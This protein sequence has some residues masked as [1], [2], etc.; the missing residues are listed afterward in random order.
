M[1]FG[2]V[3]SSGKTGS[4][5]YTVRRP[6]LS[7]GRS[8]PRP[9]AGAIPADPDLNRLLLPIRDTHHLPGLIAAVI[10]GDSIVSL[11]FCGLRKLGA[12][13]P[14]QATDQIHIGS[15]TKAMTATLVGILVE[16]GL[17]DWN[18]KI[19]EIFP[20]EA[21]GFH[22]DFRDLTLSH[23]LTHRG[24]LPHDA[25]WWRLPGRTTTEQR[26]SALRTL[27]SRPPESRPGSTYA[28]SNAGYVIA[29]L[30]AEQVTG[31]SWENL[32]R[33]GVFEPLGLSTAGFG[34]PG[35]SGRTDQPWGHREKGGRIQANRVDNAPCM[36]PAGTVHC[37]LPDWARFASLHL[38]GA[39]GQARLLKPSTFQDLHTP[40]PGF[41]YA[42]GWFVVD[43]PWAGGRALNHNGS[44]TSWYA[45]V[46]L[47]PRR[48]FATLVATNLGGTNAEK[49]CEATTQALIQ[50]AGLLPSRRARR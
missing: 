15:C 9:D 7:P 18:T 35:L 32:M 38:Q 2:Q 30:V 1:A 31:E 28:Y 12:S 49:A 5:K 26:R 13:Q 19:R 46:W 42:G 27:L 17:L 37:S 50:Y 40:P 21:T 20:E 29:G 10:Q 16:D 3:P 4:K 47:A 11:G 48:N 41:E 44:N 8:L 45:S 22:A 34:P 6:N 33:Q 25:D 43:R 23:L 14:F 24:G 36:G 39:E